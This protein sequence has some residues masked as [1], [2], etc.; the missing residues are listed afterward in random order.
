MS[1]QKKNIFKSALSKQIT[2][3]VI[4]LLIIVFISIPLA[5]NVSKQYKVNKEIDSL[6][7][8]I[9]DLGNKNLQFKSLIGYMQ[10][11]QF[12]DEKA[13]LNLNY[14]QAGESVVVIKNEDERDTI[15]GNT[16]RLSDTTSAEGNNQNLKSNNNFQKWLKYFFKK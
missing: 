9:D 11:D 10:S 16:S 14:K 8:E 4:G 6:K 15:V 5:K 3:T 1:L 7:N 2:F 12:V 13:R